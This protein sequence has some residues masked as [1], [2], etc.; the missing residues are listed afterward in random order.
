MQ[1]TD[2]TVGT[3]ALTPQVHDNTYGMSEVFC[4]IRS[5]MMGM[6]MVSEMLVFFYY[7]MRL[8]VQEDFIEMV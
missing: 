1:Y 5:L 3:H 4:H 8:M 2:V 6:E 7:L